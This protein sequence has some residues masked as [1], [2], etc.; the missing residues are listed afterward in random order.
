MMVENGFYRC[1]ECQGSGSISES[2]YKRICTKCWGDGKLTWLEQLFGKKEPQWNDSTS[3][4]TL[5]GITI[6][7]GLTSN[8]CYIDEG[9]HLTKE[10]YDCLIEMI[11]ERKNKR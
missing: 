6:G 4:N 3:H 9:Y 2:D 5:S 8:S 1:G 7:S 10:Q 11:E